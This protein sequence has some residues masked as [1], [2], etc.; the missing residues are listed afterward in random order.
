VIPKKTSKVVS[1]KLDY[2]STIGCEGAAALCEG[3]RS[4]TVLKQLHMPYCNI[5]PDGARAFA[6][7][8]SFP[9]STTYIL[10]L[11]GNKIGSLGL[12]R[13]GDGLRRAK[14]LQQLNVADNCITGDVESLSHF[15]KALLVN[16]SLTHVDM[17]FNKIGYEGA[18]ALQ[19]A[20]TKDNARIKSFHVDSSLPTAVFE[21]LY[22]E[23]KKEKKGKKKKK[24]KK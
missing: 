2:N 10:N 21:T 9:T 22:R 6:Q 19:P 13:I 16:Q 5:G 7:A 20:L 3:L 1:L 12:K 18:L 17:L 11:Q 14:A 4:N 8:M 24:K 23:A 15:A